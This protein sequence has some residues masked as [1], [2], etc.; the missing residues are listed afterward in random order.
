MG[1]GVIYNVVSLFPTDL[2]T[3]LRSSSNQT[4][5]GMTSNP[6]GQNRVNTIRRESEGELLKCHVLTLSDEL[7]GCEWQ[8]SAR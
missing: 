4:E 1:S 7:L 5:D 2:T 3:T 8:R 6:M